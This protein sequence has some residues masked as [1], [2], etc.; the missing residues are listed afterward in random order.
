MPRALNRAGLAAACEQLAARDPLMA[1]LLAAH[2]V[3]PL[4]GRRPGFATLLRIVLEQQVSL[5]SARAVY[6]RVLA[7]LGPLDPAVVRGRGEPGLRALGLTR[8]K[9][10]YWVL[11]AEAVESGALDL[12]AVAR[13]SD[14]DAI[15]QLCQLTGVGVWTAE[16]YLLMALRRPD[17]WPAG[18]IALAAEWAV[19]SGARERPTPRQL[20]A[21]GEAWRPWRAAAARL[22]W[23]AY[24]VRLGRS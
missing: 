21:I 10:R 7:A 3:P 20:A 16:C 17:I 1:E 24:L 6:A 2:G 15:V 19:R 23:A 18:D 8:Q 11:A 14:E 9:A 12:P 4:W 22:L 5:D 13:A